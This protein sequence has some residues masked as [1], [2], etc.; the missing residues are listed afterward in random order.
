MKISKLDLFPLSVPYLHD[1][2]S[3]RVHRGGVTSI[4]VR[5]T[6]DDGQVGWGE[7]CVGADATSVVAAVESARPFVLGR[8]PWQSEAIARDFFATGLWDHRAMTGNF[9]YAGIDMALWD[10]CGKTCGEPIYRMFGGALREEVDYFYYLSQGSIEHIRSECREGVQRGHTCFYLKVGIDAA[11]ETQ[12]LAAIRET[13]GPDRKL[14]IDANQAWKVPEAVQLLTAWHRDFCID[15]V[16][17]PVAVFPLAN[18][19]DLR[20]RVAVS[21]CANEGMWTEADA[22]RVIQSRCADVLCF[23]SYWVGSLRRF[24]TLSQVAHLEGL[25][26]CKHTHGELGIAAAAAHHILLAIPNA[27]DGAQQTAAMMADDILQ[28]RLPIS[29]Q[30]R[31]GIIDQPGLGVEVDEEKL[32]TYAELYRQQGQFLPY[33]SPSR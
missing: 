21:F 15:F 2:R 27:S 23:S 5:L 8:S 9:A 12:M 7:A 14:R 1:E 13:I 31:W 17:A 30:A 10:L 24:H 28:E 19:R 6:T 4:A 33:Q 16:E 26:V 29:S 3:S 25:S 32:G 20:Q 11:A 22:Y 18:M